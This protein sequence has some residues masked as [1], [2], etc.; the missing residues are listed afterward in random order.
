MTAVAI[1]RFL[2][3]PRGAEDNEP[4]YSKAVLL[5]AHRVDDWLSEAGIGRFLIFKLD[6]EVRQDVKIERSIVK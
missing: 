6:H 1:D 5:D 3:V 2:V 4:Q